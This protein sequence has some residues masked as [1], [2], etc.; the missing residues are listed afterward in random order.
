[1]GALH[2][3]TIMNQS[4]IDRLNNAMFSRHLLI[5]GQTGSGKTT[6]TLSLL[7]QLQ[8]LNQTAIIL[9]PTGEYKKLPNAI[10][11]RLGDNCY[12]E[13]GRLTADQLLAALQL[14]GSSVLKTKLRQAII[15]LRIQR[16]IR[17]VQGPY[18]RMGRSLDSHRRDEQQLGAWASDYPL[19]DL[20]AQLIEEFV[21]PYAD[22]RA[23]YT[24]LGQ[25]YDRSAINRAWPVLTAIHDQLASPIFQ[26]LFDT[27]RHAGTMKSE[28]N[29]I[30]KMF[31]HQQS[32][33]RTLVVDLSLLKD[34]EESQRLVISVL[35]KEILRLRLCDNAG[36]PVNVVIDEAHRYL[37]KD[38][39]DLADNGI[40]QLVREGRKLNLKMLLTTQSPLDLPARLRA[41]F[42]DLLVHRLLDQTEVAS[43]PGAGVTTA[44]TSRLPVGKAEL[45]ILG[46]SPALVQVNLPQWWKDGGQH[47]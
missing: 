41:Q 18:R 38:E 22:D 13:A 32:S 3:S 9:D 45:C 46:E 35:L 21:I 16:N 1:M 27:G 20:F 25:Q 11:Y 44:V 19:A 37:P 5:V 14:R 28:L 31:L 23:D 29:F 7:S 34:Y 12:L 6:S 39:H 47:E 43:L 4:T 42:G 33:H 2:F 8:Q 15:D 30:L 17:T 10:T 24:L 36:F 26:K 40:F